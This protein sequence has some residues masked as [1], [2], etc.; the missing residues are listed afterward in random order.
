[1]LMGESDKAWVATPTLT[2]G[3]KFHEARPWCRS[4]EPARPSAQRQL[5]SQISMF[6]VDCEIG[7]PVRTGYSHAKL[8]ITSAT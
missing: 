5:G 1:M 3:L 7:M 4:P 2:S 8:V 6:H